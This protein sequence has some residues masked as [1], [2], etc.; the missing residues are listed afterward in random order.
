M[1]P[2]PGCQIAISASHG[3]L[4][5]DKATEDLILV[6]S[7]VVGSYSGG[8]D[9]GNAAHDAAPRRLT[10]KIDLSRNLRFK[11]RRNGPHTDLDIPY[12]L[13]C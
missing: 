2:F 4:T 13:L 10:I 7:R 9:T 12:Q 8:R 1:A 6:T 3:R 5:I 11:R